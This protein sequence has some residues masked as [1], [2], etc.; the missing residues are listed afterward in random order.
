MRRRRSPIDA[1]PSKRAAP[2]RGLLRK[3][4]PRLPGSRVG[5]LIVL[6]L[7]ALAG[8]RWFAAIPRPLPV[9]TRLSG[10]SQ[11]TNVASAMLWPGSIDRD[12]DASFESTDPRYRPFKPL[13]PPKAPFPRLTSTRLLPAH[14][15]E[16]WFAEGELRC[17]RSDLGEE[18]RLDAT[19]LWVN[20][21][22][23][24]WRTS[25][26]QWREKEG[27]FSPDH[28]FREQNELV[29][30]MRSVI[31][32]LPGGIDTVHLL[33]ADFDFTERD[34]Q[35]LPPH[36]REASRSNAWRVAQVPTWLNFTRLAENM[37]SQSSA[38]RS[39]SS[40]E[41]AASTLPRF[42]YATH[43]EVFRLPSPIDPGS[44][45]AHERKESEW[46][47]NAL[48]TFNSMSIE[49]RV[50]WIPDLHEVT[51]ALNDDFFIL[52][53]HAVSCSPTIRSGGLADLPG[54]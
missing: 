44:M 15:M 8:L 36:L 19:W 42:R 25:M 4:L 35:L 29:Y 32:S 7:M 28:H 20:G 26:Q 50:G 22:D 12:F 40:I 21:S 6:W 24:R 31:Q 34:F 47:T 54:I 1:L 43:A 51:L 37:S 52:T 27:I 11:P 33:V 45:D 38:T 10:P 9:V 53:P 3:I 49:S 39:E 16:H 14:C 41:G 30:S 13:D 48:P 17:D 23:P 5:W 18:E 46:R 2:S